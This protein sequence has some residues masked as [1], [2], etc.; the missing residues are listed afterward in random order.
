MSKPVDV[1]DPRV[2]EKIDSPA[3]LTVEFLVKMLAESQMEQAKSNKA[4]ADAILEGRK[5][6]IDPKFVAEMEQRR[7]DRKMLVDQEMRKRA[8]TKKLCPHMNEGGKSNVKWHQHSNGII[9]GACGTC[10]SPFDATH[11]R[12]DALIL[13]Q[14]LKAMRNMARAGEHARRGTDIAL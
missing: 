13:R 11:N 10:G 3:P 2:V 4:L 7:V 5:P 14:D 8:L 9:L 12:E 6:Y 1:N